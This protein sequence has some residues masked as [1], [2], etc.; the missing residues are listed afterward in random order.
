MVPPPE[1]TCVEV[2]EGPPPEASFIPVRALENKEKI[3][4]FVFDKAVFTVNAAAVDW[5]TRAGTVDVES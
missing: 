4:V 5:E 1:F 2:D 3:A